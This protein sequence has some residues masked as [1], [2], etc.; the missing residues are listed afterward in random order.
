MFE[1]ICCKKGWRVEELKS[2]KVE[3]LKSWRVEEL[4][5]L[6]VEELKSLIV[7]WFYSFKNYVNCS[8]LLIFNTNP[9]S[10]PK[11]MYKFSFEKLNAWQDARVLTKAIYDLTKSFP[12]E[13]KFCITNQLRR[14]MI[15]VCSNLA[16][17][18]SRN[19]TREQK[20][21]YQIAFSSLMETLNQIIIAFDLSYIN[22]ESFE[23]IRRSVE[24]CSRLINGL[25]NSTNNS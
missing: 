16:E 7:E 19:H 14:A 10:T 22:N 8:V 5:S 20:Q 11:K 17:G 15:S 12:E 3:E 18:S 13:E 24:K 1:G 9:F 25:R 4:K 2:W 23:I 6:I 21:F